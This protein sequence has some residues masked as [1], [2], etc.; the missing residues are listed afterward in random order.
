MTLSELCQ[1]FEY[2]EW[3]NR[4]LMCAANDLSREELMRE[5]GASFGS[6]RTTLLHIV[7]GEWRWLQFWLGRPYERDFLLSDYTTVDALEA[8]RVEVE[9]ELRNFV[10]GLT[11][12]DLTRRHQV[13]G[14]EQPLLHT[15][16]HI[17]HHSTYHR[18]QVVTL[19]RQLGRTPPSTDFLVFVTGRPG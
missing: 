9:R 4:T 1:L 17:L 11:D 18:G 7:S 12:E 14:G 3:A 2:N 8:L 15:L 10:A 6:V 16:Q 19:L 5:M 13:R